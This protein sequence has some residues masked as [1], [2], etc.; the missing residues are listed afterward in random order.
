MKF[1]HLHTHSHYSLLDGL[2]RIDN[3]LKR[4]K[5]IGMEA[6][7]L[8]DHGN[9]YGAIEFYTKAKALGIKP[10][11]GC[12]VYLAKRTRTDRDPKLDADYYHLILL[13]KNQPGYKNLLKIVSEAHLNG[14]Y[15]K[16]K[17]DKEFLKTHSEGLI[18]SSACL[19][20]EIPQAILQNNLA[21]AKTAI[22]EYIS[23]FGKE[24]F[25]LELQD[26]PTMQEQRMVN[27]KIAELAKEFDLKLIV[28]GD[29]HYIA[30]ENNPADISFELIVGALAF[31]FLIGTLSGI[32]PAKQAAELQ[33]VDA[34]RK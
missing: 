34:L 11:L 8:T 4:A 28:T 23:I 14:F 7:A 9:M 29:S 27:K 21:K 6:I 16:P 1:V 22:Q 2:S 24:D 17:I 33:P 5:E 30:K 3:L 31:S 18:A 10:I 12:E 13:A 25:Y 32:L 15:Y 26:H 20:G 19:K